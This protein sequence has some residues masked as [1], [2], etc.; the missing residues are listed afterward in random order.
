MAP[1][2]IQIGVIGAGKFAQAVHLPCFQQ[3]TGC[4]IAMIA[5]RRPE[6]ARQVAA[7]FGIP[8]A[9]QEPS[10][11]AG[12]AEVQGL[13]VS[14]FRLT[15][16]PAVRDALRSGKPVFAEKPMAMTADRAAELVDVAKV[17]KAPFMVGF[18][19]RYDDGVQQARRLLGGELQEQLGEILFAR[20]Y[21]FSR[22]YE[23][24][25]PAV[26]RTDERS[27]AGQEVWA[28]APAWVPEARH[29]DYDWFVNRSMHQVNL[30]RFLFGDDVS[31][32]QAN[33]ASREAG[34]VA[35]ES[36]RHPILLEMGTPKLTAWREGVEVFF[37]KGRLLLEVPS[38]L[39]RSFMGRVTVE[40][41]ETREIKEHPRRKGWCFSEQAGR[42][43]DLVRGDVGANIS[44]GE[45][46]LRDYQLTERIWRMELERASSAAKAAG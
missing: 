22:D 15:Q 6:L 32:R 33:L 12:A 8:R 16:G 10:E 28:T 2:D 34:F 31:V 43:V 5:D 26:I 38:P 42:F 24:E 45:D 9:G 41:G 11:C 1:R 44:S 3:Q 21:C 4:R 7:R 17:S 37:R 29:Q 30:I 36:P 23:A 25:F 20:V 13:F 46:S 14:V 35:L 40:Y 39:E 18:M 19:K 27:P